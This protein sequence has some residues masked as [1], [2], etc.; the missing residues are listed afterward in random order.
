METKVF[1][2]QLEQLVNIESCSDDPQGLNEM[3]AWFST[4]FKDLGWNVHEY[5]LAPQSGTCLVCTN[6]EAEH[7]DVLLIGHMDTV[8]PR[9]TAWPFSMDETK[10][11]GPGVADMKHGC[12]LMYHLMKELPAQVNEKLNICVVFNPDE[13]I[14]SRY[15]L[16]AYEP[17]A[18]KA[19]YAFLYEARSSKGCVCIERKGA[20]QYKLKFTGVPGHCGFVFKN[21]AKSAISE[22]ARWIVA[23]D[24]LQSKERNT[25]VNVGVAGGGTKPNVVAEHAY[26][27]VDIRFSDPAEEDRVEQTVAE[28]LQQAEQNGITVEIEEKRSKLPLVPNEKAKAYFAHVEQL[29]KENNVPIQFEARGGLSDANIIARYGAVCIDGMGPAGGSGHSSD[30]YMLIDSV[31]PAYQLSMLLLKD[32]ANK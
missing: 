4:R 12:L 5:D 8:F 23:L 6:R 2:S 1:L 9:G 10:V 21:G 14:G 30:E 11:Y 32:L 25:S 15:S 27:N 13:E 3:A 17:Y 31:Q 7:Y 19:E 29:C 18:K 24:G 16:P 28:L 26:I 20:M 22:M